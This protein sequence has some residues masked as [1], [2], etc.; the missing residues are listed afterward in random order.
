[1][2]EREREREKREKGKMTGLCECIMECASERKKKK[3][4]G[5]EMVGQDVKIS[6][7]VIFASGKDGVPMVSKVH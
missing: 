6:S 5:K 3:N 2:Y 4:G 7:P 1:M